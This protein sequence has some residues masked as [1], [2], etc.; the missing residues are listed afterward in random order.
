MVSQLER[1]SSMSSSSDGK[2]YIWDNS[3]TGEE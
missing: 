3:K 2:I 1:I